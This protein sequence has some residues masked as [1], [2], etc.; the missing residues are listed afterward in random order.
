MPIELEAKFHVEQHDDVRERLRDA[1]AEC[2]GSVLEL[3]RIFDRPDGSMRAG[4]CGLRVRTSTP[5]DGATARSTMTF[6][7]P[8]TASA[9]K[10]REEIEVGVDDGETT[11]RMLTAMG[12]AQILRYE[13][14]RESWLLQGARIELD[15]PPHIGLFVEIEAAD[16]ATIQAIQHRIGLADA[17]HVRA[18]YVRMLATYCDAHDIAERQL[19]RSTDGRNPGGTA[20]S[21]R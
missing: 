21:V 8:V 12:F 20:P 13:K 4:G 5:L 2:L 11:A 1:G 18:S 17:K 10:S 9:Y 14:R 15:E 19:P 3:N 16:E 6:K 7:G